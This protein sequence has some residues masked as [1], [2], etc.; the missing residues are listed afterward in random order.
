MLTLALEILAVQILLLLL[1]RPL[2]LWY[3]GQSRIAKALE[4]ID[5]SLSYLP[6]VRQ[7]RLRRNRMP[8]RAA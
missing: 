2:L 3:L 4:S 6:I 8:R 1:L 7:E 5:E